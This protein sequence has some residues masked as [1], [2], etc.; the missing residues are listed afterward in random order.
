MGGC[1]YAYEDDES[2]STTMTTTAVEETERVEDNGPNNNNDND[3]DTVDRIFVRDQI[4]EKLSSFVTAASGAACH[5]CRPTT[6][7]EAG[8]EAEKKT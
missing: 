2:R 3:Y 5:N 8:A 7:E 1:C 6:T 4:F